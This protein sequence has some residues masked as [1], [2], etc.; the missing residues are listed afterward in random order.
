[1]LGRFWGPEAVGLYTRASL[2]INIPVSQL[3]LAIGG[4]AFSALARLQDDRPLHKKYFLRGYSLVVTLTAPITL[5]SVV[6]GEAI[7]QVLLGPQWN[8]ATIIFRLLAPTVLFFGIVN[9]LGW[10]LLTSGL[11]RRS[12]NLALVLAPLCVTSYIVGLSWGPAGVALVYSAMMMIWLVPHVLWCLK[13]TEI[14]G[15]ELFLTIWPPLCSAVVA[16][17]VAYLIQLFFGHF[18]SAIARL[19]VDSGVMFAVYSTMLLIVMGQGNFYLDLV[20]QLL[21]PRTQ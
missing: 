13:G 7:I 16:T 2:L 20:S 21:K 3:N 11:Q 6:F 17:A 1:L 10:L 19:A 18:P 14:S 12:L 8:D 4:V 5:F 9:P 15:A